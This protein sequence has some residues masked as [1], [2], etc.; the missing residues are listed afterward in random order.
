MQIITNFYL[1]KVSDS[2]KC[3]W[4]NKT[5]FKLRKYLISWDRHPVNSSMF[6]VNSLG[7]KCSCKCWKYSFAILLSLKQFW[8]KNY[9]AIFTGI[10]WLLFLGPLLK[11]VWQIEVIRSRSQVWGG[12][13]GEEG[14]GGV[15][16]GKCEKCGKEFFFLLPSSFCVD[17][18]KQ[19]RLE[20]GDGMK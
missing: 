16:V 1:V 11:T 6:V 2:I 10:F 19:T 9:R 17:I 12:R 8:R 4:E 15:G 14:V 3:N 13:K 20:K 18:Y 7:F 5:V